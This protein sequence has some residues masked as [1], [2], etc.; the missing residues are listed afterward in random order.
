ME[1]LERV[2]LM[3]FSILYKVLYLHELVESILQVDYVDTY[4]Y[5]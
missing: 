5:R 2:N 3:G 1:H 4:M